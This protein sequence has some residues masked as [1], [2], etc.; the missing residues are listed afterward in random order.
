MRILILTHPR[1]GGMTFMAWISHEKSFQSYHEPNL[2]D[3]EIRE[4]VMSKDNIVVKMFLKDIDELTTFMN[5]FDKV[6]IHK[7]G[8]I[9]DVAISLLYGDLKEDGNKTMHKV[10]DLNYEWVIEHH[11]E[12]EH[13]KKIVK[14][15]HKDLDQINYHNSIKTTYGSIFWDKTDVTKI[16]EY[17]E[18]KEPKWLDII[19]KDRRLQNGDK[20]M[21]N[22]ISSSTSI[23]SNIIRFI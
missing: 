6:I 4:K 23:R 8:N 1:S 18:I 14:E 7:R 15:Q 5:A 3:P 12:I 19:N 13:Y 20:G 21:D 16:C 17:I 22:L 9:K 2:N 11:D 10:Y